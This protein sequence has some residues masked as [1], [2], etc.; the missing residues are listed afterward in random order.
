MILQFPSAPGPAEPLD[1][2]DMRDTLLM[3]SLTCAL[4]ASP[5]MP[6]E[7]ARDAARMAQQA[8]EVYA[9]LVTGVIEQGGAQ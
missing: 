6:I 1:L 9:A 8:A 4:I 5:K 7:R 2:T 3:L